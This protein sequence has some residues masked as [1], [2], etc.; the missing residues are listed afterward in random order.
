MARR[1]GVAPSTLRTWDRRYGVGPSRHTGG[2]HR[3][4]GTSD[5]VRLELMQRA[6]LRGAS[7][8]EAARFALD[9]MPKHAAP[10]PV[11]PLP[12]PDT[13]P[14]E[15][16]AAG[17]HGAGLARFARRLSNAALAMDVPLV[18]QVLAESLTT[19]GVLDAW[20]GVIRPVLD[21]LR[22]DT[23]DGAEAGHLVEECAYTAVVRAPPL[24]GRPRNARPVL[25]GCAPHERA[26]LPVYVLAAALAE[27][28]VAG[29]PLGARL[30]GE[31]LVAA[32]RR[33]AP[34]AVVLWAERA[35]VADPVLLTRLARTRQRGRLFAAGP[36]WCDIALPA[37]VEPLPDVRGAVHRVE[38]VLL[39]GPGRE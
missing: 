35:S 39:G 24:V 33:S 26:S 9:R 21:A 29:Q 16:D 18:Q 28:E 25:V 31:V 13:L 2:R 22:A 15:E 38:Y 12:E 14:A 1:L 23:S 3:R 6:L 36:G 30:S 20:D 19:C 7:T 8:A 4:Y 5:V 11:T 27:R 34:S 32:V 37:K 17:A 10:P